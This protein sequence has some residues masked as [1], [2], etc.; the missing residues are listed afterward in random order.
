MVKFGVQLSTYTNTKEQILIF[1]DQGEL[2]DQIISATDAHQVLQ[3][4]KNLP[5]SPLWRHFWGTGNR[6]NEE[7]HF[8]KLL[9]ILR[10]IFKKKHGSPTQESQPQNYFSSSLL[11]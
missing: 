6:G 8:G 9:H 4:A 5:Y 11:S 3:I 7:N 10:S 1:L 2:S